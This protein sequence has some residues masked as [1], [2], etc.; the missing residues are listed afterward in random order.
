MEDFLKPV[1]KILKNILE[2]I[3]FLSR[4]ENMTGSGSTP[5][6]LSM[7]EKKRDNQL[8]LEA[9]TSED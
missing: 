3:L 7:V 5:S 4:Q 8:I 2:T 9:Q 6:C 1:K